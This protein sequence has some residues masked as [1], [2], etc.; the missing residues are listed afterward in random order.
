LGTSGADFDAATGDIVV[1]RIQVI[2][3]DEQYQG[4]AVIMPEENNPNDASSTIS[5]TI[6]GLVSDIQRDALNKD[7]VLKSVG[8]FNNPDEIQFGATTT[9]A[10]KFQRK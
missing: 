6:Q 3:R 4:G 7:F 1:A 10:Q 2:H 8:P 5:S 9:N